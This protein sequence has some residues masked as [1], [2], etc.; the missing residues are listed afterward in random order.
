MPVNCTDIYYR[1]KQFLR[2]LSKCG[3]HKNFKQQERRVILECL[4]E[5]PPPSPT[6]QFGTILIRGRS[7]D[8]SKLK[9]WRGQLLENECL[10]ASRDIS[11]LSENSHEPKEVLESPAPFYKL[12]VDQSSFPCPYAK[13]DPLK[14]RSCLGLTLK[15]IRDV[16]Q[17]LNRKLPLPIYCARCIC[18]FGLE[19]QRDEHVQASRCGIQTGI[20]YEGVTVAQKFQLAQ[21]VSSKLN[22]E[23]QWFTIFNILF[24]G[25][26][27][28]PKSAY[29]G[30]T[31]ALDGFQAVTYAE[32]P[33]MILN[34]MISKG[35]VSRSP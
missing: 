3:L 26:I 27:A 11:S 16:K 2:R 10:L 9:R 19:D 20:T 30:L 17:H 29:K 7:L 22:F 12:L 24:P 28:R 1:K 5:N 21:K 14:Y 34:A 35:L 8:S 31:V 33:G 18:I 6:K 15:R 32:G 4:G 13:K 25:Q 23:D